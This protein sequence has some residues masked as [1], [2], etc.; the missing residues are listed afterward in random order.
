MLSALV[1]T[2]ETPRLTLRG[3]TRQDLDASVALWAAPEVVRY[4]GG[5]A[6]SREETWSKLLRYV[7]H[8]AVLGFGYWVVCERA[9]GRFVGEVGFADFER[10]LMPSL[11]G[12]PEGGWVLAPWAHGKGF[13]TEA[14]TAALGWLETERGVRRTAF[15]IDPDNAASRR[16]AAKVGYRE[17]VRTTYKGA[18]VD[19]L[20][21]A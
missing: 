21:R 15:I 7:G 9:T 5:R 6:F 18:T 8:W 20:F 12:M 2:L 19:V 1:P 11:S 13:A 3:H 10:D 4:I 17:Q 16:V 14:L